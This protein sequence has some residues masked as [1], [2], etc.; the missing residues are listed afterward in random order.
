MTL[1]MPLGRESTRRRLARPGPLAV[2]VGALAALVILGPYLAPHDP[3]HADI[4]NRL[5]S[6][7]LEYPLGTDAMGRCV[8]SRL[9]HGAQ[10]T[11]LAA[12]LAVLAAGAIGTAVGLA[13]GY[14]GGILDRG[15]MRLA[16]GVSVLPALAVSLVVAGTLGLG[17]VAVIVSLVAVHW[18]EYAR[19]VRNVTV[20]ERSK[21]YIM[22]A[23]AIGAEGWRVMLR[24]LLPNMVAPLLVLGAY[25]MSW[26][27]LSFAGMSFLGLGVEPGTPEWGR[28]IAEARN[29]MRVHPRLVL[30][31]GLTIMAFVIFINL[32]ADALADRWRIGQVY[33]PKTQGVLS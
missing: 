27:I 21:P 12:L 1:V 7:S 17:L 14:A 26:V 20:I 13:A 24:H 8:L 15:V 4:L 29:H 28:M 2:A 6:P 25:S 19:V 18:T 23:E 22:A 31:P 10:L 3:Y 32:L 16:E 5:S 30:A 11:T 33:S 9:F